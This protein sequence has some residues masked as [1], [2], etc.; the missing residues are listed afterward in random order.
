MQ[1]LTASHPPFASRARPSAL[2]GRH[3]LPDFLVRSDVFEAFTGGGPTARLVDSDVWPRPA[4]TCL[5]LAVGSVYELFWSVQSLGG[6]AKVRRWKDVGNDMMFR[7]AVSKGA[8]GDVIEGED[9]T[10]EA[11]STKLRR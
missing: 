2:L 7:K 8:Q 9:Q 5:L 11:G 1:P 6:S 10:H 3:G 4:L